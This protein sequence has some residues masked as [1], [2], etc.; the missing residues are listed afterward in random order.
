MVIYLSVDLHQLL[1]QG[2]EYRWPRPAR[3]PSCG[4]LRLWSHGY[5]RRNFDGFDSSFWI[6]RFRC[7]DCR[8]V[9]TMRPSGYSAFVQ[10]SRL[11]VFLSLLMKVLFG[12]WL[13]EVCARRQR[14]WFSTFKHQICRNRNIDYADAGA[15]FNALT[16]RFYDQGA[17]LT[18]CMVYFAINSSLI[19]LHRPF[20]ATARGPSP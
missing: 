10:A 11:I 1:S 8:S 9:H 16:S 18:L 6:K 17:T 7:P 15:M 20:P 14:Y 19:A 4:G 3:C 12:Q 13:P 5:V 2:K